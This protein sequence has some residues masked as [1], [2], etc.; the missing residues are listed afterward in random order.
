MVFVGDA[1]DDMDSGH[2][3]G[4]GTVLI[5]TPHNKPLAEAHDPTVHCVIDRLD[6]LIAGV[7]FR[8]TDE[9]VADGGSADVVAA[10]M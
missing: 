1:R 7:T 8:P 10:R 4:C 5:R 3:A 9:G 6:D 2:H